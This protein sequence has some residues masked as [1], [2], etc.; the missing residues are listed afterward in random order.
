MQVVEVDVTRQAWQRGEV[1][2]VL[3][4][5]GIALFDPQGKSS[6]VTSQLGRDVAGEPTRELIDRAEGDKAPAK[7][8]IK[9]ESFSRDAPRPEAEATK[10]G[11]ARGAQRRTM[12]APLDA[13]K[14]ADN[15][16]TEQAPADGLELLIVNASRAQI[17]AALGELAQRMNSASCK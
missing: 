6:Q 12:T 3:A 17:D 16:Q 10:N 5:N 14:P 9:Q 15:A 4:R 2:E 1:E 13:A 8:D 11:R 7:A